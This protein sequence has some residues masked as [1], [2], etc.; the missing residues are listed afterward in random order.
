MVRN[1]LI[2]SHES[3]ALNGKSFYWASHFL[4]ANVAHNSARL[5]T[6]CRLLDD[7]ADGE[8][9]D[10]PSRLKSIY[11]S[12]RS[13]IH[14]NDPVYASFQPL[15]TE[16][17]FPKTVLLE[18]LKG[19]IQDLDD[20][21]CLNTEEDLLRYSYR[22]AG[23]V[24]L[25]MCKVLESKNSAADAFAIDLGIGMQLTNIAR[26]VLEDARM[27]RRYIPANWV[28]G[29]SP[30]AI[31][32][33]SEDPAGKESKMIKAALERLLALADRFYHSG[34][35]GY[36]F[37]PWRAHLGIAIAA[38]VY[39][40]IGVQLKSRGCAWHQGRQVTSKSTKLKQ[41]LFALG[42]LCGRLHF[43]QE[44]CHDSSLHDS[45]KGLPY[46]K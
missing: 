44:S 19:L 22:V 14:C 26:D 17:G 28:N 32:M 9:A 43:F 8:I 13:G 33:A 41:S 25:L 1:E 23:T 11:A 24:G 12:L 20:Q 2:K 15:I 36:T 34:A 42:S 29:L 6:F 5:Y 18:L 3:L 37:L 31:C 4:S 45:L 16:M 7:M 46:V 10:G 30:K 40:Q 38:Q 35:K 21:V 39:R 27:G